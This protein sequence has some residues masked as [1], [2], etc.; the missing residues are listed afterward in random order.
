MTI[1]FTTLCVACSRLR[2][3]GACVAFPDGIP[4]EIVRF[5]ADHRTP[6]PGDNG[7]TFRLRNANDARE[8]LAE[9]ERSHDS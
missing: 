1:R 8:S 4:E 2:P 5:G 3:A 7:V 6:V 9:W